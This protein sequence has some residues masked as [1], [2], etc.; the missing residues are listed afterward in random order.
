MESRAPAVVAVVVTTGSGPGLEATV[1]SLAAQNYEELSLLV[2]ANGEVE[3][4]PARVAAVAPNAFVRILDENRGFGAACNEAALMVEGS[5]FFLFCHDDVRLEPD[6]V[7][8]MVEAAFRTNA[9]IVTPKVVAYDDP[10]VLLHVGQTCDRFGV[11]HERSEIGEIDHGQQDLERDVFVAPGGVTLV[12]CDLF[13]TLRGFDPL[14]PVLGED[15]DLCWRAQVAGARIVVVPQAKVAHRETV[16]TGERPVTAVGTRRASRADLK[17]RHQ[18]LVVATGW[19]RLNTLTTLVLLMAMDTMEVLLALLGRDSDRVGAILGSW[20]W[21]FNHRQRIRERRR[22][23][24]EVRVLSDTD[25]R[26]LQVGGASR[27]KRFFFTLM[28]DGLDRARG[29]LPEEV[30]HHGTEDWEI[31]GVGFAAAFSEDEEFDEIPESPMLE[32]RNRPSRFLTSFRSQAAVVL[33]VVGLWLFGSRNLVAMHLPLIGRLAPLDS[34]WSMWRHFFAS[35][36][37]GGVGTGTPGMPGFGVLGIAGTFVL[38]RMGILPRLALIFAV[39]V[40][41]VG[42]SRL[43]RGRVSNRARVVASVFYLALPTG[44]NM[45]SAGRVDVLLV[46]ALAPYIVRRVFELMDVPGFRVRPYD[47]PVPFGQRGWRTTESG[48]RMALV[49]L[50]ALVSAM[51]PATLIVTALVVVG[52]V[53]ARAFEPDEEST[54]R[55]PLR[56][57]GSLTFNVAIFLLPLSVDVAIAGRRALEVFGLARGPWSAPSFADLARGVDGGFSAGWVGWLLPGAAGLGLLLCRGERRRIASKASTIAVLTLIVA[58][59]D[60]R[61]WMGAF[62][63]DIDVLLALYAVMLVLLIG[64]GVSALENDLRQVGFGWRQMSAAVMVTALLVALVPFSASFASG[65]FDLPTTSVAESLSTLSPS[66][67]GGYRVLWIGDPSVVPLAGWSVAPGVEAATSMNGLPGGNS[68]FAPPDSGTTDVLL[69]AVR[70]ALQGRTVRLGELLAPAG[71]STIVVMNAVAP[72]LPGVQST[73]LRPVPNLLLTELSRQTD[74]SLVLQTKSVQVF[75]NSLFHGIVSMTAPGAKTYHP[76][77]A[78]GANLGTLA[79]GAT[80]VAGLAPAGA[81]A[82][83]VNGH[84]TPRST[85]GTWT[86]FYQ[87]GTSATAPTGTLVLHQFPFNGLLALFTLSMWGI[88]WLGFGWIQRLEWLFTGRRRERAVARHRRAQADE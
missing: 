48:Q 79:S 73:P 29:I 10:L 74:L 27:L 63:P 34:W 65:R 42:V 16:A 18:L 21:L 14:I 37:P 51:A 45:I 47:A 44:L 40:G 70:L 25:L 11:V 6:A 62:A 78:N 23:C 71:V 8:L 60:A 39:P 12:R 86:P 83:D 5:A 38:G 24:H 41:A 55:G 52:V 3:H 4:V 84:S 88:V 67:Y 28:R 58:V 35:W 26:R 43:L 77:F 82:L 50:I 81:F 32:L 59:L 1:A 66:N 7:Q 76:V 20:R 72:E 19:G 15:L 69:S 17:R 87:V 9:G 54:F 57:L 22:Q 53:V 2:V 80:V 75:S 13:A 31:D 56:F 61:H 30:H 64:L 46:V 33:G 36:S 85:N 68:I 49:M